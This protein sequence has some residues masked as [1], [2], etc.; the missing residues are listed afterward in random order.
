MKLKLQW[1]RLIIF[2]IITLG[3]LLLTESVYIALG[4]LVV[5]FVADHLLGWWLTKITNDYIDRHGKAK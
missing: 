1:K 2:L 5:L 3:L 4:A